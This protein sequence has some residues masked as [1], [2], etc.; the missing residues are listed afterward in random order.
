MLKTS[1]LES[2]KFVIE[3]L[4]W[5]KMQSLMILKDYQKSIN[6]FEIEKAEGCNLKEI[7]K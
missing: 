1:F 6:N 7:N 2:D 4:K 3:K 5:I